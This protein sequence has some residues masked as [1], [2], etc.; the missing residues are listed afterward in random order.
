MLGRP[1]EL[2]YLR[3]V[4]AALMKHGFSG[5]FVNPRAD[6]SRLQADP[7]LPP[8]DRRDSDLHAPYRDPAWH[9]S[10]TQFEERPH[11]HIRVP[12]TLHGDIPFAWSLRPPHPAAG[13]LLDWIRAH[14][15]W[16]R[17]L[18]DEISTLYLW[19]QSH[20]LSSFTPTVV[21][22]LVIHNLQVCA[23]VLAHSARH[24]LTHA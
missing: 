17:P 1:P 19:C 13:P 18:L 10:W 3:K 6:M 16:L 4:A 11:R 9:V 12:A 15:N 8:T 22:L 5:Y 7:A 21:A 24:M 20:G 14:T 2:K 23:R